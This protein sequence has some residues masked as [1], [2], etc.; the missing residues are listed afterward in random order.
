MRNTTRAKPRYRRFNMVLTDELDAWLDGA[1]A[2][3]RQDSGLMVTRSQ[4]TRAGLRILRDAQFNLSG[5][6]S[7]IAAQRSGKSLEDEI[8]GGHHWAWEKYVRS[9]VR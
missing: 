2:G 1:I 4:L 7:A 9:A 3:I 8:V 6:A 5:L